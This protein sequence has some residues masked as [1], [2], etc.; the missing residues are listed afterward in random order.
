MFGEI[1]RRTKGN[2]DITVDD[3]VQHICYDLQ[4]QSDRLSKCFGTVGGVGWGGGSGHFGNNKKKP[5]NNIIEFSERMKVPA[6]CVAE[7]HTT[8]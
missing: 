6:P 5:G 8:N 7:V 1:K 4:E 3:V 2:G